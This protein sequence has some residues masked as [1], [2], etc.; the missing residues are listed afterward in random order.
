[1]AWG[2][3]AGALCENWHEN[4]MRSGMRACRVSPP[5]WV[6][7][8]L[9]RHVVVLSGWGTVWARRGWSSHPAGRLLAAHRLPPACSYWLTALT[10][11]IPLPACLLC[12]V[13]GFAW[14]PTQ[15]SGMVES[16][17]EFADVCR[18]H[19]YHNFVFSMKASNPL[20]MVQ[21]GGSPEGGGGTG[22]RE[23]RR[24]DGG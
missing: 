1:M 7:A 8:G 24:G 17:F 3:R 20:V 23:R 5:F 10:R 2:G 16:A 14:P 18:K 11:C 15:H 13:L 22:R 6:A 12:Y 9:W 19:D 4:G 21:V